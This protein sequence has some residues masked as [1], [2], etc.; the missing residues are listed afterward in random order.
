MVKLIHAQA[1][2]D[3]GDAPSSILCY[4][5]EKNVSEEEAL[6]HLK[7][8]IAEAWKNINRRSVA[9]RHSPSVRSLVGLSSNAAR[10]AHMLYQYG[11]GFGIQ[12]GD[13]RR[14]ILSSLIQPFA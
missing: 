5:R 7:G 4:M 6:K 10:V 8:L 11:D 12:D 14:Q 3:R 2:K 9:A 1:E 13:I